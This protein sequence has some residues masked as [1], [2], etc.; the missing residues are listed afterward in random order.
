MANDDYSFEDA[1]SDAIKQR[2][3]AGEPAMQPNPTQMAELEQLSHAPIPPTKEKLHE[4]II[5]AIR[6]VYDPELPVNLYDLGLIYDI[7]VDDKAHAD[8]K[9]TLTAPGCPVAGEMPGMVEQAVR[10]V[11]GVETVKAH[12]VWEPPWDKSMMSEAAAL[13]LGFM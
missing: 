13:E 2:K 11:N 4:A 1:I 8:I 12:L 5:A 6:T 7:A 9:M 3:E 10:Y